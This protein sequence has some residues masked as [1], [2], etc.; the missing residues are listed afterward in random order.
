MNRSP[1]RILYILN[2]A[3]IYGASRC[4]VRLCA[5]LDR[6]RFTPIVLLPEPG[7][8]LPLLRDAHVDEVIYAQVSAITRDVFKSWRL[9][10]FLFGVP[11][12]AWK[13]RRL[14]RKHRIDLVHTNVGV[15]V[16]SALG[17]RWSGVPHVWHIRDWYGEFRSLWK[18][19]QRFILKFSNSII[20][21]SRA[22][23]DQFPP[24][25]QV[26]VIHDGFPPEEFAVDLPKLRSEFR[27]RYEI[28]AE[29]CVV[30][31]VGRIKF[32]RKGQ[33][34]LV[35]ATAILRDRGHE[36]IA[37]IVGSPSPGSEDHLPQLKALARDLAVSDKVIFT[38]E[39]D[40]TRGAYAALDI[41][42]LTSGQPEP[43]GGVVIEA[44]CM[45]RPVIATAL[46]GSLDQVMDGET[47]FL[48]PPQDPEKLAEKIST[49]INNPRLRE[50]MGA[51]AKS[52]VEAKFS[53]DA[54]MKKIE[55]LYSEVLKR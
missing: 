28:H 35:R 3:D 19:Y 53:L 25:S 48:I 14:I 18:W 23:A 21:V 46:G 8:L 47:G 49:L 42:A 13:L 43:F 17:A 4:V 26:V 1:N 41:L 10:P 30:G 50:R 44:M 5:A 9:M 12:A 11:I 7:P 55:P 16:S 34:F 37:L 38:G 2:S 6:S 40:D 33:E 24:T 29:Q 15:I 39:L 51:S 54:M 27:K 36:V 45:S 31:C 52:R 32:V 22:I 20:C